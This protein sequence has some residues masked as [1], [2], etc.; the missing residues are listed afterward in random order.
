[1][2]CLESSS[3]Q[4]GLRRDFSRVGMNAQLVGIAVGIVS[5]VLFALYYLIIED[6]AT[7]ALA[8]GP[9]DEYWDR[10]DLANTTLSGAWITLITS[11]TLIV[12]GGIVKY[13]SWRRP[14]LETFRNNALIIGVIAGVI[15]VASYAIIPVLIYETW[16]TFAERETRMAFASLTAIL[17]MVAFAVVVACTVN[18]S[19]AYLSFT[20]QGDPSQR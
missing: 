8:A 2:N 7:N 3:R 12:D 20:R 11:I 4:S 6:W 19:L 13:R 10:L 14:S 1:V 18:V 9:H 16:E 15:C 5:I 17:A